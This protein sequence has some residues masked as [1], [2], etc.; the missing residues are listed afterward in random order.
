MKEICIQCC[1][2]VGRSYKGLVVRNKDS[3]SDLSS[4]EL[5][6]P[7]ATALILKITMS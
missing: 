2:R 3:S 1:A 6:F 4:L 5:L 7:I